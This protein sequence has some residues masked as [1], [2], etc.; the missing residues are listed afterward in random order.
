M[1]R[2]FAKYLSLRHSMYPMRLFSLASNNTF[3]V[4]NSPSEPKSPFGPR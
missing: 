1:E 4:T 2:A 3:S